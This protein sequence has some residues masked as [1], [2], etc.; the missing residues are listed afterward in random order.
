MEDTSPENG[1]EELRRLSREIDKTEQE[2]AEKEQKS[3]EKRQVIQGLQKGLKEIKVSVAS[4]Q[5]RSVATPDILE[6]V[7]SLNNQRSNE[8]LR[9]IISDLSADLEKCAGGISNSNPDMLSIERSAKT[10]AILIELLFSLE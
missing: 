2:R 3:A 6:R 4:E 1:F 9:K 5:L 7:N 8:D 10:L